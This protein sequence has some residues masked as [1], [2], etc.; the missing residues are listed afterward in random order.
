[1]NAAE[2]D[3]PRSI[4]AAS[5]ALGVVAL[6][7]LAAGLLKIAF[8]DDFDRSVDEAVQAVFDQMPEE[9][10]ADS[11]SPGE[12]F[13]SVPIYAAYLASAT[14]FVLFGALFMSAAIATGRGRPEARTVTVTSGCIAIALCALPN[15]FDLGWVTAIGTSNQADSLVAERVRDDVP[16]WSTV[17]DNSA[18]ILLIVGWTAAFLLLN[19]P[20]AEGFLSRRSGAS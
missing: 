12:Q 5:A 18:A 15:L 11:S 6:A 14:G 3:R 19:R 7:L 13:G 8:Y 1:M 20:A 2:P 17:T 9:G 10:F 16:A 4:T